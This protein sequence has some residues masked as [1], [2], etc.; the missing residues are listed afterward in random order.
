M[1][2]P[3]YRS[4]AWTTQDW[5]VVVPGAGGRV[6]Y[7]DRCGA[8]SN[9][10]AA[11]GVRLCLPFEVADQLNATPA[12]RAVLWRQARRKE[13]A[14]A[15]TRV[16]W[17]P[18]IASLWRELEARTPQDRA[19]P[20]LP[21]WRAATAA[22]WTEAV[23]PLAPS[24][25]LD[26]AIARRGRELWDELASTVTW[27]GSGTNDPLL[28]DAYA[29]AGAAMGTVAVGARKDGSLSWLSRPAQRAII[30]RAGRDPYWSVFCDSG[31]FGEL[32]TGST[33]GEPTWQRIFGVY[34]E[35]GRSLGPQLL[36]VAPDRVG[37]AME[38]LT[39]LHRYRE[40]IARIRALG[41][42]VMCVVQY[43]PVL[44]PSEVLTRIKLVL[45]WTP[46]VGIPSNVAPTTDAELAQLLADHPDVR[47]V[48]LLGIGPNRTKRK[49]GVSWS[50]RMGVFAG[51]SRSV[52]V[53][54][55]S[56]RRRALVGEGRLLSRL[57]AEQG[58]EIDERVWGEEAEVGSYTDEIGFPGDWLSKAAARRIAVDTGMDRTMRRAW[59]ADPTAAYQGACWEGPTGDVERDE[60]L[61]AELEARLEA[62]WQLEWSRRSAG[63]ARRRATRQV[64]SE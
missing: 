45:G 37:D 4:W 39:R 43:D 12:D 6:D 60:R 47:W 2:A 62:E 9:R 30:D 36:V 7:S 63:T 33:F 27:Y 55:D 25:V 16:P 35:L 22:R 18:R 8:P 19:N 61:C 29:D 23:R 20:R 5:R 58:A 28:I 31:A 42:R 49:E 26:A 54:C 59:S 38:T 40:Q 56:N 46:V 57:E 3:G 10:T 32:S 14:A 17:H 21:L 41:V 34:E 53:T 24:P 52:V 11:G 51:L 48:H 13:D 44:S 1:S 15:G 64:V 50:S